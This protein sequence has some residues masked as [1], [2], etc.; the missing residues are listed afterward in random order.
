MHITAHLDID[1]VAVE[2]AEQVTV[3]LELLAPEHRDAA[4]RPP[5]TVQVVL[6]RSGSMESDGRIQAA[7]C[8]LTALVDR[9]DPRDAFGLV[10][11]DDEVEVTVP[12]GPVADK[13]AIK[14]AIDN[15]SA[16]GA[17]NL[18][19]G[20]LRGLQEARRAA[21][22]GGATLLLLS[23]GMANQ[24]VTAP[25]RLESVAASAH[26]AGVTVSTI[27]IGLGYDEVLLAAIARGG[28]GSHVFV[29]ESDAA[30]AAVAGEGDGLLHKTV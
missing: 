4:A 7:R 15:L 9:L 11:F 19:G 22:R 20:L 27:G 8:A 23:D 5:A 2:Q 28:Q 6:D 25:E 18:S 12:A 10:A 16:R 29:Q 1:L 30:A 3:M 14:A 17:T 26:A 24:G 21:G 13:A